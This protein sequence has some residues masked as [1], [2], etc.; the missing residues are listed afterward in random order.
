MSKKIKIPL[1]NIKHYLHDL[2]HEYL[3]EMYDL[4]HVYHCSNRYYDCMDD[5][6]VIWLMQNGCIFP[7]MDDEDYANFYEDDDDETVFPL[8]KSKNSTSDDI[9]YGYYGKDNHK[10]KKRNKHNKHKAKVIDINTPYSGNEEDPDEVGYD[11]LYSDGINNGKEIFYYPD[12]NNKENKLEFNT[13]KEFDDFCIDNGY[14]VPP[15]VG[16]DIAYRRVS[17]V[18]LNPLAREYGMFEIMSEESYADMMYEACEINRA[19]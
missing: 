3:D 12:Y 9:S 4:E 14:T 15:C 19:D 13:L 10:K 1:N 2:F 8:K 7:G 16:E 6:E 11:D 5:D 17:H 18:C